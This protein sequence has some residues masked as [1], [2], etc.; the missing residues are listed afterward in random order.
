[1]HVVPHP[2]AFDRP[3]DVRPAGP[4]NRPFTVLTLFNA[5]SSFQRKNPLATI[6]AFR[7]AFGDDPGARLIIKTSYFS[8]YPKG[9]SLLEEQIGSARNI[10]LLRVVLPPAKI[11]ALYTESDVVMSL[12]RSEGF[13]LILAEAMMRGLPVIATDWSG[14]VDF[15]TT[16]TG[17]PIP[18]RL[19]QAEDPQGTYHHPKMVWADADVG[20]AAEAL[21]CLR[22]NPNLAQRLGLAGAAFAADEW[23]AERYGARV[24]CRLGLKGEDK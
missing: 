24:R 10:T 16:K 17:I 8:A 15:V 3:P 5:A 6:A 12:H 21:R 2:V 1:V 11:D 19:V 18:C 22:A 23:C 14:N 9:L 20:A 4:G 7:T 13:G